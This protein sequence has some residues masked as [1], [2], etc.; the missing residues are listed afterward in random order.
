[1]DLNDVLTLAKAGF[2]APQITALLSTSL[3][4]QNLNPNPNTFSY[5]NQNQNPV[6]N[7]IPTA[8]APAP[9]SAPAPAPTP[10][11]APTPAPNPYN[12][13]PEGTAPAQVKDPFQDIM[14]QLGLMQNTIQNNAL[15]A[16]QQPKEQTVDDILA[17]I[18]N[19]PEPKK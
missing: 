4:M 16:A 17:E 8:P 3:S 18:I 2:T 15:L 14:Q 11:Q 1:M 12:G 19:P 5:S 10:T 6:P 7:T 9:A 13:I